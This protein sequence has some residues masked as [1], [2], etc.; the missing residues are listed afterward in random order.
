MTQFYN[1]VGE[2]GKD[3]LKQRKK[4]KA[5]TYQVYEVFVN[6]K[7]GLTSD[8]VFSALGRKY[9]STSIRRSISDL[10]SAGMLIKTKER[11][12]GFYGVNLLFGNYHERSRLQK[13]NT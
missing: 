6:E 12:K 10:K 11:K 2:T 13:V 9:L 4:A 1:S 8:D 3:L 5:Q 7:K